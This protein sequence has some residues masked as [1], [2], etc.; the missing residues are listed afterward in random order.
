MLNVQILALALTKLEFGSGTQFDD[1]SD[2]K[3]AFE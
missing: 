1:Y 2:M 3:D